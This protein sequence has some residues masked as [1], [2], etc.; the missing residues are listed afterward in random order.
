MSSLSVAV[1]P[2]IHTKKTTRS[3]MLDVIIALVPA[4]FASVIFF[5]IR[6]IFII[7]V[8]V[9]FSVLS[10]FVFCLTTKKEN[11]ISDLSAVVTGLLLALNVPANLPLWQIAFGAVFATVFVKMLF[12]GVGQNFANPAITARIVMLLSFGG[13]MTAYVFPADTVAGATPLALIKSGVY[14]KLPSVFMLLLGERGGCLGETSALALI[15]GFIYLIAKGVITVH[16]PLS[17]IGTV[18]VFSF[19]FGRPPLYEILTGGLLLGAIFMATDYASS[20]TKK[21]GKVIFGIGCGVITMIIRRFGTYPEG[22]S[23]A[24]LFMNI[25]TPYIEKITLVKPLG[26]GGGRK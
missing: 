1:S 26:V 5:G 7:S 11:S 12:G 18:F 13:T 8:G 2:H 4:I 23:F 10:E 21:S 9:A 3:I 25:L 16:T 6:P 14:H 19:L 24:I 20:P 15:A 17:F 22:V